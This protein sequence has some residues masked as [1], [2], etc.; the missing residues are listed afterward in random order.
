MK[1]H[2]L[3]RAATSSVSHHDFEFLPAYGENLQGI[4]LTNFYLARDGEKETE[5]E[6]RF[7]STNLSEIKRL[8]NIYIYFEKNKESLKEVK[9]ISTQ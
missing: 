7:T 4:S 6:L 5:M 1:V 2:T 3:A 8:H 9:A